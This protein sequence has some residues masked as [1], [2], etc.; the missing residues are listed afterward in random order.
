M[1]VKSNIESDSAIVEPK[2]EEA[3]F[4]LTRGNTRTKGI[5]CCSKIKDSVQKWGDRG[6]TKSKLTVITWKALCCCVQKTYCQFK[7][8]LK[9]TSCLLHRSQSQISLPKH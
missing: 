4:F 9:L 2:Q 1:P 5:T 3:L 6:E 7:L 8:G